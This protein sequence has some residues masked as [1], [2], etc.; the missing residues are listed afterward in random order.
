MSVTNISAELAIE[1]DCTDSTSA[2]LE[3][4]GLYGGFFRYVTGT[5]D[6][7]DSKT[8][9]MGLIADGEIR[10]ASRA[11]DLSET[12][13]YNPEGNFGFTI[14]G[15]TDI[16]DYINSYSIHMIGRPCRVWMVVNGN[17]VPL[18]SGMVDTYGET[19][20]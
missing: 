14:A 1:I 5:V 12:G 8:W 4:V 17:L 6:D 2:T 7:Y 3:S 13:G 10:P 9:G 19:E 20:T 18:W 11:I 16:I 15:S